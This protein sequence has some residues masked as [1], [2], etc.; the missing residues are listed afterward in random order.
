MGK[1]GGT[2]ACPGHGSSKEGKVSLALSC[3]NSHWLLLLLPDSSGHQAAESP[4]SPPSSLAV[5]ALKAGGQEQMGGNAASKRKEN[6]SLGKVRVVLCAPVGSR[7]SRRHRLAKSV[8]LQRPGPRRSGHI[9][10]VLARVLTEQNSL[11]KKDKRE[12]ASGI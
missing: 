8:N 10:H 5:A 2:S 9:L 4:V 11:K 7:V 3:P 6:A 12:L 1:C